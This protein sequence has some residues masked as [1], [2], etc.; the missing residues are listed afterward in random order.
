MWSD[1]VQWDNT[2]VKNVKKSAFLCLYGVAV[3]NNYRPIDAPS[4]LNVA[5]LPYRVIIPLTDVSIHEICI[6]NNEL[7]SVF[8]DWCF[9]AQEIFC[10]ATAYFLQWYYSHTQ[11]FHTNVSFPYLG[12]MGL[13]YAKWFCNFK[14]ANNFSPLKPLKR[15]FTAIAISLF[16][17]S[18]FMQ[19][20]L[21]IWLTFCWLST[22]FNFVSLPTVTSQANV[23]R[24]VYLAHYNKTDC[25]WNVNIPIPLLRYML[26]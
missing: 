6:P 9:W 1:L 16:C 20:L 19:Y 14:F 22:L 10:K 13:M 26:A 4:S 25:C 11:N 8:Y 21:Y 7:F 12:Y 23:L 15:Y 3:K 2:P 5:F 24:M 17:S 18:Y